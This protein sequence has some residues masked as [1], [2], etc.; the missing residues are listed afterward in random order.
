MSPVREWGG[1]KEKDDNLILLN[2]LNTFYEESYSILINNKKFDTSNLSQVHS[3]I[4]TDIK[5]NIDNNIKMHFKDYLFRFVNFSFKD[6]NEEI[7]NEEENNGE[8]NEE[9]ES[10]DEEVNKTNSQIII[11]TKLDKIFK[12]VK[13]ISVKIGDPIP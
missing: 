10:V 13:F 1:P 2:L 5:T 4:S 9:I 3:Y 6:I 12:F 11:K 7:I 8:Y